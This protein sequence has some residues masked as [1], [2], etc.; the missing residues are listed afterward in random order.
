M[1]NQLKNYLNLK[2]TTKLKRKMNWN[3][4]HLSLLNLG[5]EP[6]SQKELEPNR[7]NEVY[8]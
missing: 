5:P 2:Y 4:Q 6:N 8:D 7:M 1:T 3:C